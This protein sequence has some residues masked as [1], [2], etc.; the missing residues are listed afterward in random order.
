MENRVFRGCLQGAEFGQNWP[1][2]W[3]LTNNSRANL[4]V[5]YRFLSIYLPSGPGAET[6]VKVKAE[7]G[8]EVYADTRVEAQKMMSISSRVPLS[9]VRALPALRQVCGLAIWLD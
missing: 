7:V 9:L 4:V 1:C 3:P 5:L 6:G 8:T 2:F